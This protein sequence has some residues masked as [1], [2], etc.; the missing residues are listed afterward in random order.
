MT[1]VIGEGILSTRISRLVDQNS[2]N[3]TK[4]RF[5]SRTSDQDP[6]L[7]SV[8]LVV[9]HENCKFHPGIWSSTLEL[10]LTRKPSVAQEAIPHFA[11][12]S[13]PGHVMGQNCKCKDA[14]V[15]TYETCPASSLRDSRIMSERCCREIR[16]WSSTQFPSTQQ[17]RTSVIRQ[18]LSDVERV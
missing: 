14:T 3:P 6:C 17:L 18:S 2:L 16:S 4:K 15:L 8:R 12:A 11:F 5:S 7:I 10:W 1:L 13:G 9:P